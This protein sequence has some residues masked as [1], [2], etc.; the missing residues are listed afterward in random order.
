M[1]ENQN[2]PQAV[3]S[4][5]VTHMDTQAP[6]E[7]VPVP[8]KPR[9]KTKIIWG[10]V[11]LVA[12]LGALGAYKV[13]ASPGRIWQKFMS[14][15]FNASQIVAHEDVAFSYKDNKEPDSNDL[16]DNPFAG[17]LSKV[18]LSVG[19]S[20]YT[21]GS[22]PAAPEA[23]GNINYTFS[24]GGTSVSATLQA[25]LKQQALYLELG[26]IPFIGGLITGLNSGQPVDWVKIDFKGLQDLAATEDS[27]VAMPNF[28]DEMKKYQDIEAA[29]WQKIFSMSGVLGTEKIHNVNTIHFANTLDKNELKA[30]MNEIFTEAFNEAQKMQATG[31]TEDLS[32]SKATALEA[33]DTIIDN[34]EI[35]TFE[36]WV[37]ATDAR[38]YKLKLST[39][40]PSLVSLVAASDE[41]GKDPSLMGDD[42]KLME[43]IL[44]KVS[45]EGQFDVD[46][47]FY[48][49]G[50]IQD[51]KAPD[52]ALDLVQKLKDQKQQIQN[53]PAFPDNCP[54]CGV[55]NSTLTQ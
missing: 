18:G 55:N 40:A 54:D 47:E 44:Q 27:G 35:K 30:M 39:S 34:M 2:V 1:D 24:S 52:N 42:Q 11:V 46:E 43:A 29:H 53:E 20:L 51:V 22:N 37:G 50:K 10:V 16:K 41:A 4:N 38:L 3:S 45:Y 12:L 7:A 32:K 14:T 28:T 33:V 26:N 13:Y 15:P 8:E 49:Y 19:G 6:L 23:S 25:V 48:D 36:T 5:S 9:T 21:N 31:T 17:M